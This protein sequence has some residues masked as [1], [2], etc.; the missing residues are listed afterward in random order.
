VKA[1]EKGNL[2]YTTRFREF[3]SVQPVMQHP[4]AVAA[5]IWNTGRCCRQRA[6]CLST[7]SAFQSFIS[8]VKVPEPLPASE[9]VEETRWNAPRL[10][11]LGDIEIRA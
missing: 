11:S 6:R 3:C 1:S 5:G 10:S 2:L 7:K 8:D 4:K 9:S